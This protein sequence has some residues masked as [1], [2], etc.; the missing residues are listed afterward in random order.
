[1]SRVGT[2]FGLLPDGCLLFASD[3]V[4]DQGLVGGSGDGDLWDDDLLARLYLYVRFL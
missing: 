3:G 4:A 1:M 2:P